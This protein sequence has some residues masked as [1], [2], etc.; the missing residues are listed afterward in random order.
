MNRR[1]M[2][3]LSLAEAIVV[4]ANHA[5]SVLKD[6][7]HLFFQSCLQVLTQY[8]SC[9]LNVGGGVSFVAVILFQLF[10]SA[11]ELLVVFRQSLHGMDLDIIVPPVGEP[12]GPIGQHFRAS[13]DCHVHNLPNDCR[14]HGTRQCGAQVR[15]RCHQLFH[16]VVRPGQHFAIRVRKDGVN[17]CPRLFL[18]FA[19]LL[20]VPVV[21]QERHLTNPSAGIST[22][23]L[24][25]LRPWSR[26]RR[27]QMAAEHMR[28]SG[29][30]HDQQ[31]GV[32]RFTLSHQKLALL[33]ED[34]FG[35]L[36][37]ALELFRRHS[38]WHEMLHEN[39]FLVNRH[40]DLGIAL[41]QNLVDLDPVDGC[42]ESGPH[43]RWPQQSFLSRNVNDGSDRS[44]H[45]QAAQL[46]D[47]TS[48]KADECADGAKVQ[49]QHRPVGLRPSPKSPRKCSVDGIRGVPNFLR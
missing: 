45:G 26:G 22:L 35:V 2:T 5:C 48:R 9:E 20:L 37:D 31:Q 32:Q 4:R 6:S 23:L 42:K 43:N 21:I 12:C 41:L 10:H 46:E 19:S 18:L 13:A 1:I 25:A 16:L 49:H 27:C 36:R 47:I 38:M 8:G 24:M 14:C 29:P 39:L 28:A 44:G 15:R 30:F 34:A 17:R 7:S 11:A 33:D 3:S 40:L